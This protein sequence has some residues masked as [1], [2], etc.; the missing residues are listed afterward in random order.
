MSQE[1]DTKERHERDTRERYWR[2]TLERD[3]REN[4]TIERETSV[5]R[6]ISLSGVSYCTMCALCSGA[7]LRP[8]DAF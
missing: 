6:G 7:Y 8:Q 4:V 3:T 2:E 1:S 5:Y